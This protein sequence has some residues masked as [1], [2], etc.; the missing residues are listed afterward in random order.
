MT[1]WL[2]RFGY[3]GRPF[4]GWARQP[5]RRT[6]EE[7]IRRGIVRCGIAPDPARA[8]LRVASRTDRGVSARGNALT[9]RSGLPG[10]ALLGA[11]NG[12]AP[13]I[14]F[15]GAVEVPDEFRV[16]SPRSREY[17]YY[18]PPDIPGLGRWPALARRF[19]G[20]PIDVRSFARGLP[21]DRPCWRSFDELELVRSRE[22]PV[23]RVRAPGF[24][25]GMVRKI[26]AA[27]EMAGDGRI[28]EE[29]LEGALL[30]H[31]RVAIPLAPPEPLLLWEVDYGRPWSVGPLRVGRAQQLHVR[32][33]QARAEA[34]RRLLPELFGAA[35]AEDDPG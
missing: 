18:L 5:G 12:V 3:D 8:E 7:E 29:D 6:V 28:A 14:L 10:T 22:G 21:S 9:L 33:E 35:R 2:V 31:R 32:E 30:G 11:L 15:T 4:D 25:W 16:R 23:L 17:R 13:E 1:R 24:L 20:R 34:R 19:V 27:L 26:V